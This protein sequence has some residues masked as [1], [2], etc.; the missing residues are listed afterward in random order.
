MVTITY[1]SDAKF[2]YSGAANG[3]I[4]YWQGNQCIKTDKLHEG[5]IMCLT[6]TSGKLLSSGSKDNCIK[7]SKDGQ[8]LK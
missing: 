5:S 3:L 8:V 1:D 6:Y 4:Y 7:I 2:F